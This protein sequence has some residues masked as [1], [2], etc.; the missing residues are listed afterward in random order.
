MVT[1]GGR[2]FGK[3]TSLQISHLSLKGDRGP[4]GLKGDLGPAGEQGERGP[5]GLLGERGL[6]GEKGEK[7][8]KGDKGDPGVG[9]KGDQ[10]IQGAQGPTGP[11]GQPGVAGPRGAPSESRLLIWAEE[12]GNITNGNL[13]WSFGNGT[14]DNIKYGL[15]IPVKGKIISATLSAAAGS[16]A[17]SSMQVNIII[18]G[19]EKATHPIH[20]SA[21]SFSEVTEFPL[22]LNV[23]KGD[24]INFISRSSNSSV[25]HALVSVFIEFSLNPKVGNFS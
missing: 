19:S 11:Q 5:R 12:H 10:G 15:C 22:P 13:E 7:G 6:R 2:D 21:N 20:L 17:P 4:Q 24:R 16:T 1:H 14:D 9:L 23:E 25:T 18:N 3:Q 8:D